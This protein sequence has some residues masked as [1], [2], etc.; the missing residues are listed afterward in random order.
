MD[1]SAGRNNRA[2]VQDPQFSMRRRCNYAIVFT[3]VSA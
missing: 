1:Y 2:L 3:I